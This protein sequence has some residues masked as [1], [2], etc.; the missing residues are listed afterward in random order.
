MTGVER[1]LRRHHRRV[2]HHGGVRDAGRLG[3]R[4]VGLRLGTRRRPPLR[5]R[6]ERQ[7]EAVVHHLGARLPPRGAPPAPPPRGRR[8]ARPPRVPAGSPR[9]GGGWCP[10]RR[11]GRPGHRGCR[12]RAGGR[13]QARR[14]PAW[15]CRSA[16]TSSVSGHL[17][18][19]PRGPGRGRARSRR[20]RWQ[21][22]G[23]PVRSRPWRA[24][25][26]HWPRRWCTRSRH[27]G[28]GPRPAVGSAAE[29]LPRPISSM[30][31][32]ASAL[33]W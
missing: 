26:R 25:P 30:A 22:G 2:P 31:R 24:G 23:R 19:R 15:A 29:G 28:A 3:E 33:P 1:E 4:G 13:V 6:G 27:S 11:R 8:P 9:T 21:A 16:S 7:L 32:F 12:P 5:R 18:L 17:L 10:A 14:L 20:P